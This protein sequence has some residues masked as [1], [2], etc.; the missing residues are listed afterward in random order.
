[1]NT[2]TEKYINIVNNTTDRN[3]TIR[4]RIYYDIG[5]WNYGTGKEKKR[6][7]YIS[8]QPIERTNKNGLITESYTGFTGYYELLTECTRKSKKAES[9]ALEKAP[10]YEKLMID[11]ICNKNGYTVEV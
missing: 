3:N 9:I 2:I 4:I 7:Y 11:Y 5:G 8:V 1:M 10:Y 6:G